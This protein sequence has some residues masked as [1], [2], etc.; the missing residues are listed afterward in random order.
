MP[1]LNVVTREAG[2]DAAEWPVNRILVMVAG[3]ER[4]QAQRERAG[5]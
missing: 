5:E 3:L 2:V 4:E 1:L